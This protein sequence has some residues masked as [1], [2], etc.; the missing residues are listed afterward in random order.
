LI[1]NARFEITAYGLSVLNGD[2]DFVALNGIDSW[3]GGVHLTANSLWR[4]DESSG[5]IH[6]KS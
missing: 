1:H 2:A 6:R 4:W 3:L 5:S